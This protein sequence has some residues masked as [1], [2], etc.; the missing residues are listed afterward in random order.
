LL[1]VASLLLTA[2]YPLAVYFLLDRGDVRLA[3]LALLLVLA[4]RFLAPGAAQLQVAAALAVGALFAAAIALTNSEILAR[5]Y[6]V[7]VSFVL[8][9][10]FGV[11]LVRPP[12][13]IERIARATGVALNE[14]AMRYTRTVTAIWCG[15]FLVN[16]GIALMTALVMSREAWVLYNGLLSYLIGGAILAGE[17][18]IRPVF[19]RRFAGS[20]TR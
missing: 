19:Q 7:A 2:I 4:M 15:F 5:L 14:P 17:R 20:A 11:T 12:S 9:V 10:A 8:L 1:S 13:M 16:G 18:V 3:G 6:P